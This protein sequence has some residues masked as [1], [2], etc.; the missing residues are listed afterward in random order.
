MEKLGKIT[1]ANDTFYELTGY[2]PDE[3]LDQTTEEVWKHLLRM[4]A[5]FAFTENKGKGYLFTKSLEARYVEFER[6]KQKVNGETTY[7]A[8]E[9]PGSR[10]EDKNQFVEKVITDN[11]MGVA[12]LSAPDLRLIKSNQAYMCSL[13]LP[14]NSKESLYGKRLKDFIPGF[15]GS[16]IEE[17]VKA[18]IAENLSL[19]LKEFNGFISTGKSRYWDVTLI[20]VS[21]NGRVTYLVLM[22]EEVTERVSVRKVLNYQTKLIKQQKQELETKW[23]QLLTILDNLDDSIL[24]YDN[25]GKVVFANRTIRNT[26][27]SLNIQDLDVFM[28]RYRYYDE[29]GKELISGNSP[30][31]KSLRGQHVPSIIVQAVCGDKVFYLNISM[32]PI[33]NS[34][35]ELEFVLSI[36]RNITKSH[37]SRRHMLSEN[38]KLEAVIGNMGDA[39]AVIDKSG[40]L[41]I[42]NDAAKRIIAS[43]AWMDYYYEDGS[44]LY[45]PNFLLT[46]VLRGEKITKKRYVDQSEE[47]EK[48][49][50]FSAIPVFDKNGELYFCILMSHDITEL[51]QKDKAIKEQN[52]LLIEAEKEKLEALE[53]AIKLKDE[54]LYLITHEFK[55]PIAVI[56]SALQTIELLYKQQMPE[57][58]NKLL[59][60][61]WQNTNR[62]LRLVNNLLDITRISAGHLNACSKNMDIVL[63]TRSITE[64]IKDFAEQKEISLSFSS[65]LKNKII[66]IDAEKYERILLNLLSNAVKYTPRGKAISVSVSQ[67]NMGRK[68]KV[69]IQ[70]KDNGIGIP[71][72]KTEFIFE[73]FGQVDC[74]LT[75][76]AEGSG[77]GLYLVRMLV[78]LLDGEITLHSVEGRGSTFSILLPTL[79]A[80][81]ENSGEAAMKENSESRLIEATAIEFSDI[82]I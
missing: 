37:L 41:I 65:T 79:K 46:T 57:K 52:E 44:Q 1:D 49:A 26:L 19:Y 33:F 20:P 3:L 15:E 74:S 23:K 56:R 62:E 47:N 8:S 40:R 72:D 73:R 38:K 66:G 76:Q 63:L 36:S 78:K 14:D 32:L 75:R 68:S 53:N 13:P 34:N 24:L 55:T 69:C 10:F 5:S 82:Y 21:E 80:R 51:I 27:G 12:V 2:P 4:D 18:V 43:S 45:C 35:R 16:A 61:I 42:A 30:L 58:S 48:Y 6:L 77:I 25:S 64:S 9:I 28:K 50:E 22:L 7:L 67:K 54:F 39:L 31:A 81:N 11:V 17:K 60:C 71:R 70:V 29:S 59:H